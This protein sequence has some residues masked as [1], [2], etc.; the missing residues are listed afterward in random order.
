MSFL[1]YIRPFSKQ[2]RHLKG[3]SGHLRPRYD[4]GNFLPR[5]VFEMLGRGRYPIAK[6]LAEQL[7][8]SQAAICMRLHA[9]GKVQKRIVTGDEKWI[10]FQNPKRH[11][12]YLV[13]LARSEMF[14]RST[15]LHNSNDLSHRQPITST[16]RKMPKSAVD[17]VYGVYLHKNRLMF[18]N[19]RFDVDT[20]NKR[21]NKSINTPTLAS[22]EEFHRGECDSGGRCRES[23]I[24]NINKC[25]SMRVG[26]RFEMPREITTKRAVINVRWT[27]LRVI[28]LYS[29]ERNADREFSHTLLTTERRKKTDSDQEVLTRTYQHHS[30]FSIGYYMRYSYDDSL[31]KY[32]CHVCEKPFELNDNQI[33]THCHLTDR[34]RNP[35]YSIVALRLHESFYS[36]LLDYVLDVNLEY[37]ECLHDEH[38]DLSFCLHVIKI[39]RVLQF[40]QPPRL[41]NYIE[42]NTQ[43][44]TLDNDVFSENLIA[45]EIHKLELKFNKPIYVGMR[46][47]DISKD[48][49]YEFHHEY[50][51][52]PGLAR[53]ENNGTILI[54]FV[55]LRAKIMLRIDN[56][57]NIKK[58]KG[59]K[60]NIIARTITCFD[61]TKIALS[62]YDDKRYFISNSTKI[63]PR[64]HYPIYTKYLCKKGNRV[65]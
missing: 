21:T 52:Y 9:M 65:M 58:A 54:E 49:L 29:V 62:P 32:Q 13:G 40:A 36:S 27:M 56:K 50:M 25:N 64:G 35:A 5:Y 34:Y 12:L 37:P 8:V 11:A 46:I 63:L 60:S 28:A 47:L 20:G 30:V 6:M 22:L 45:I 31:S 24:I 7:G 1:R 3:K 51:L 33:S 55:R 4:F 53:D 59:V 61:E 38:V 39:H 18:G 10:Y 2:I 43:F 44:R 15:T 57:K 17:Y 23:I 48:C 42:L 41:R 19:K 16:P 14:E 26:C